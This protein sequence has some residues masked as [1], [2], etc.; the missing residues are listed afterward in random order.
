MGSGS[1]GEATR[2]L[3]IWRKVWAAH[4]GVGEVVREYGL[5]LLRQSLVG[6]ARDVA[7]DSTSRMPEDA[8]LW[9]NR[10]VIELL[11]GDLD[12]ARRCVVTSLRLDPKDRIATTLARKLETY[13]S[14]APLPK[15]LD[16]LQRSS[17]TGP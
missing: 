8:T 13:R 15:T 11:A 3:A 9:C 12:E 14:G 16:E 5:E 1:L 10:G 4:P 17:V 7:R 2:C 6:E